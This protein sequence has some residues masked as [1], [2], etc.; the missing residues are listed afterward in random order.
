M[1]TCLRLMYL[2][3]IVV[4]GCRHDDPYFCENAPHHN[5]LALDAPKGCT[6][7]RD[8]TAPT[9]VCDVGATMTC[10]ECTTAEH[11]ACIGNQPVC[12]NDHTCRSCTAHAECPMSLACLP[13]GSC[14]TDA[15]VAYVDPSG[16]DN[17]VCSYAMPCTVVAKA[18]AAGKPFVKFQRATGTT[19]EAVMVKGGRQVTFLADPGAKLTRTQGNGAIVTVQDNATSLT[20]YDLTISDA[21]NA[22]SGIGCVIPTGG[23]VS[24]LAI[25]RVKLT[26][27]PGGGIS[28][29][30][31]TVTVSQSTI[32]G[33]QGSGIST[34]GV[35]VTISQ[36]MIIG[37]RGGGISV[38][39]GTFDMTNNFI[40][41]NGDASVSGSDFGGLSLT[42]AGVDRLEFNTIA[43]NHAKA[44][45]LLSAGVACSVA[46][47]AAPNNLITSNNEGVTFPVQTKGV[48]TFGNSYTAP[49]TA[50][51]TLG[52]HST[53]VPL[54]LHLTASSPASVVDAAGACTGKDIDGDVRP[55]GGACDLGADERNP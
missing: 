20:I 55:I 7:D 17:N 21:P 46:S 27:N 3:V 12:G 22:L 41:D 13:D 45:T 11:D 42:G 16:T 10:V 54:D 26:N 51:N 43:Y 1:P 19:D 6:V 49:G 44:G 35:A 4:L 33:N 38:M 34:M 30:G 52:F 24:T 50:E 39:N 5:C 23:G 25:T 31:G 40:T 32:S 48:C 28:A 8:C 47:F 37:N 9:A 2:V 14:G 53:S 18:L 36:S 15:N 29:A